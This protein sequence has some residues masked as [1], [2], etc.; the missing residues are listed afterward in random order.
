M[1]FS[2]W[3]YEETRFEFPDDRTVRLKAP[4]KTLDVAL[5]PRDRA[6]IEHLVLRRDEI[7]ASNQRAYFSRL[8]RDQGFDPFFYRVP[9]ERLRKDAQKHPVAPA[10]LREGRAIALEEAVP[11]ALRS[12]LRLK[13][14]NVE[15]TLTF[16][17]LHGS[18]LYDP[19]S[20]L[21]AFRRSHLL[22][23]TLLETEPLLKEMMADIKDADTL[24]QAELFLDFHGRDIAERR[25]LIAACASPVRDG[26][27][28]LPINELL[29]ERF[30]ALIENHGLATAAVYSFLDECPSAR[31]FSLVESMPPVTRAQALNAA[32]LAEGVSKILN[33]LNANLCYEIQQ[34]IDARSV[35]A[36]T[37]TPTAS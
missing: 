4:W 36:R 2:L 34:L 37:R 29:T 8:F 11:E 23:Q 17:R 22:D 5:D 12:S 9:R 18:E 31:A 24:A 14:W 10:P 30:G 25:A 35:S 6:E 19:V 1:S 3:P 16:A 32:S 13:T 27:E 7:P 28:S 20:L 26:K 21:T 33:H 15:E